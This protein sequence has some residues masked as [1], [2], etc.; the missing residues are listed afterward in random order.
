MNDRAG[1]GSVPTP[2]AF[3][4]PGA[5][6]TRARYALI[7]VNWET[8]RLVV[9]AVRSARTTVSDPALL[10]VMIVDNH[11]GDD[12]LE[13]FARELPGAEVIPMP[14]NLGFARAANA[15]LAR[16]AEPYAFVLNSDIRFLNNATELLAEALEAD[17]RAVLATPKLF[18]PDQTVQ[19]S[20]IPEPSIA[21]ELINRSVPRYLMKLDDAKVSVVPSLV[22]ACMAVHMERARRVGFM[23]ERFFFY[24][25]ETDWCKRISGDGGHVLYVP[26]AHVMHMQGESA[27]RR[28][29]RAR[30]QFY[31]SRYK[32][33]HKHRGALGVAIL[34][35]GFCC[36]L[37]VSIPIVVVRAVFVPSPRA[38]E[39]VRTYLVLWCWHLLLCRPRWGFE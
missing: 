10:R 4:V 27:L 34:F 8:P 18:R 38:R 15:G 29:A 19:A 28:P 2:R 31:L 21:W 5:T 14:A 35:L 33:F 23:D 30:V 9:E 12:S 20:A 3:P 26:A 6:T 17:P 11:S 24:F 37:T 22:G 25:E 32:Y 1:S 39:R 7:Y 13:V 36:K 16:V